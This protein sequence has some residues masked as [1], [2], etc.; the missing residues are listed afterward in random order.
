M[1]FDTKRRDFLTLLGGA[2]AWPFAARAQPVNGVRRIGVLL[3]GSASDP[4][5][6]SCVRAFQESLEKLG[7]TVGQ[8]SQ[9]DYRW[10]A[11]EV[12]ATTTAAE[13]LRV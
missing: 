2:A 13:E 3:N 4:D 1:P 8:S 12:D 11:G 9:I 5:A 7:W 6:P 10:G